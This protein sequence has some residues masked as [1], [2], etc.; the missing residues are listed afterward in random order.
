MLR[1]PEVERLTPM[2]HRMAGVIAEQERSGQGV[3]E[4]ARSRG[5]PP[6]RLYWW[7]RE[8]GRRLGQRDIEGVGSSFAEAVIVERQSPAAASAP[9]VLDLGLDR[10]VEVPVGFDA[11]TLRRLIGVITPC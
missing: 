1:K 9:L 10:R 3:A 2:G 5:M 11:Q 6:S 4:F 8:I 7:R